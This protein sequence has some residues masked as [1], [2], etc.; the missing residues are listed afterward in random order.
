VDP[1][2]K[3]LDF[4]QVKRLPALAQGKLEA[5]PK[6]PTSW[7]HRHSRAS[8]PV[9]CRCHHRLQRRVAGDLLG[10]RTPML[11]LEFGQVQAPAARGGAE[12]AS[13][14]ALSSGVGI[15]RD[16]VGA[17]ALAKRRDVGYGIAD[18][19]GAGCIN[20]FHKRIIFLIPAGR[21]TRLQARCGLAVRGAMPPWSYQ[22]G[23]RKW[24]RHQARI[25]VPTYQGFGG[26]ELPLRAVIPLQNPFPASGSALLQLVR[27]FG[28]Q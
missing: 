19:I 9:S 4:R 27:Q 15:A 8:V 5:P 1:R 13:H 24:T 3:I 21:A 18:F 16:A 14:P 25:D 26:N 23:Y 20:D 2:L 22:K 6:F 10:G 7:P 11:A 17:V 12:Y 28:D